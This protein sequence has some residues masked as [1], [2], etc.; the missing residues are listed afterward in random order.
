MNMSII[1]PNNYV[2][3]VC[4][5]ETTGF[6]FLTQDVIE[7]SFYRLSDDQQ[8]TWCVKPMNIET[9]SQDALRV[10]GHKYEDI[11]HQTKYGKEI[12][13]EAS[14]VIIEIENWIEED[15][16]PSE[17]RVLCGQNVQFDKNMLEQLW[18]KCGSSGSFP[19]G[20]RSLDTMQLQFAMDF[21]SNNMS[22]SY[23]LNALTKK[24]GVKNDKAH[25]AASDTLATKD[26]FLKQMNFLKSK[27]HARP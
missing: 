25:S 8:K 11:T 27:L 7:V 19:F 3:Y 17:N 26:V 14:K 21:C 24:Y 12:Y 15:G 1:A 9:I 16:V 23:S 18:T 13:R 20:R 6:S 10:N 2:L 22:Q 4:D 5:T